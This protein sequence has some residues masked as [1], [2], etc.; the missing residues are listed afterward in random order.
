MISA[1]NLNLF[2]ANVALLEVPSQAVNEGINI[3]NTPFMAF[4]IKKSVLGP[5]IPLYI[6]LCI[7][8]L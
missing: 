8:L 3:S 4:T 5:F 6:N 7:L 2:N 1:P